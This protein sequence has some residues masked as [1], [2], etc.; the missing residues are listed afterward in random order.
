MTSVGDA[1]KE[2]AKVLGVYAGF[3]GDEVQGM[4][5]SLQFDGIQNESEDHRPYIKDMYR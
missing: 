4:Y 1:L 5:N 2:T 3:T